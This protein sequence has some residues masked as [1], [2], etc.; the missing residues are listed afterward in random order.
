MILKAKKIFLLLEPA[1]VVTDDTN[2]G[3]GL[4]FGYTEHEDSVPAGEKIL[5][6]GIRAGSGQGV[7]LSAHEFGAVPAKMFQKNKWWPYDFP[8]K[9]QCC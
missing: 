8:S 4:E 1:I 7:G 3:K 5:N 9:C 2:K 6:D